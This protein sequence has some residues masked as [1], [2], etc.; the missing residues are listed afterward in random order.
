MTGLPAN[1][2]APVPNQIY[3]T[4]QEPTPR[5]LATGA[6]NHARAPSPSPSAPLSSPAPPSAAP[7]TTRARTPVPAP[8]PAGRSGAARRP[9]P[10]PRPTTA[11]PPRPR[12]QLRGRAEKAAAEVAGG[13]PGSWTRHPAFSRAARRGSSPR[14]F[15]TA[16]ALRRRRLRRLPVSLSVL[17]LPQIDVRTLFVVLA[18]CSCVRVPGLLGMLLC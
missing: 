1:R 14:C 13:S 15:A 11:P 2:Q 7:W 9:A 8:A 3:V 16:S 12:Q 6:T 10:P 17:L 4:V 18:L 5:L